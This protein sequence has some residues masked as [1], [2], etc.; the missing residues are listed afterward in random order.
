MEGAAL[1]TETDQEVVIS[2]A[3]ILTALRKHLNL[4]IGM[5]L[6][7]TMFAFIVTF[8]VMTPKYESSSEILIDHRVGEPQDIQTINTYKELITSPTVL[9]KV[10]KTMNGSQTISKLKSE[11]S[12]SN[13]QGSQIL[14]IKVRTNNPNRAAQTANVTAAVFRQRIKKITHI[15][16]ISVVSKA[17]ARHTP[18]SPQVSRN[19]LFG[20]GFGLVLGII[21]AFM[22]SFFD[23]TVRSEK[24]LREIKLTCL[25]TIPE[26]PNKLQTT[27]KLSSRRRRLD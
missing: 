2:V 15:D 1:M 24:F 14:T 17:A 4:I 26:I 22:V 23:K 18:V 7:A 12:V 25:G 21:S 19:L 8:F 20:A 9:R 10:V 6:I 13:Q 5:T 16:N 11:I 3:D 27:H